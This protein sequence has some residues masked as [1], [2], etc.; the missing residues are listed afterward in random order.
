MSQTSIFIKM[1]CKPGKRDEAVAALETML[2]QV[3]AEPGTL[4]YSFHRDAGDEDVLWIFELYR[5]GDALAVHSGSDAMKQL[6]G[7]FGD[8]TA[9]PPMFVMATPTDTSK[10]LPS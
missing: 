4:V 3:E 7:S 9:E 5:D 8:L 6:M 2:P 10:G 1:V